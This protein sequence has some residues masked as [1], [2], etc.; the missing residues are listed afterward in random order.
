ML[1]S[2][3]HPFEEMDSLRREMQELMNRSQR[4]FTASGRSFPLVNLYSTPEDLRVVAEVP[5]VSKENLDISYSNGLLKIQ[6][7]RQRPALPERAVSVRSERQLGRFEKT[8]RLPLEIEADKIH[9]ELHDGL[10]QISL[11]KRDS[12]RSRQI[13]IQA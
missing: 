9:A 11:P 2:F 1:W 10:L 3:S 13:K 6:G 12:A 7:E 8:I 5:G 4:V